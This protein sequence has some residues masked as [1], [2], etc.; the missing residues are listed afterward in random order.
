LTAPHVEEIYEFFENIGIGF[1]LLPIYR[2]GYEGQQNELAL[3]S[4][5]IVD[6]FK[7]VVDH[8]MGTDSSLTVLPIQDYINGVV[9][10]LSGGKRDSRRYNKLDREIVYIIDTDGSVYSNADAYDPM[11]R[12]GNIFEESL[13]SMHKS[14][15]YQR[16]VKAAQTRMQAT[17][18]SCRFY[19]ACSGY[20]MAEATPEQRWHD[21]RGALICGVAQP[22]QSYI[23]Q[24]LVDAGLVDT[25]K[26][27]LVR[28][29]L[30]EKLKSTYISPNGAIYDG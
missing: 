8:W 22:V 15:N 28:E 13:S 19:G 1:R 12:H 4:T 24:L 18:L 6:A 17:C 3:T 21:E 9:T 27:V 25:E 20:F 30:L 11:L 2:T 23:E 7:K 14:E 26:D 10:R 29:K 16:A 5:E